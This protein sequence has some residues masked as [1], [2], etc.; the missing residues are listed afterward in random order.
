MSYRYNRY[1]RG[2]RT[3]SAPFSASAYDDLVAVDDIKPQSWS[4]STRASYQPV[5]THT[6]ALTVLASRYRQDK[7]D[8]N[9][10]T[11]L[12]HM[13]LLT[14]LMRELGCEISIDSTHVIDHLEAARCIRVSKDHR[15]L[16]LNSAKYW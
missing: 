6:V 8:V 5:G 4:R 2:R 11:F 9:V 13:E 10:S 1:G 7:G 15:T 14:D 3:S 16:H 12:D